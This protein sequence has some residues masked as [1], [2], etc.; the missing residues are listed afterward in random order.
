MADKDKPKPNISAGVKA[1]RT[2]QSKP[3]VFPA[4]IRFVFPCKECDKSFP[5]E[6]GFRVNTVLSLEEANKL[7]ATYA[8]TVEPR[9]ITCSCGH[10]DEYHQTDVAFYVLEQKPD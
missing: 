4:V 7:L 2:K 9:T 8:Q 3:L 1:L 6:D 5:I 10:E